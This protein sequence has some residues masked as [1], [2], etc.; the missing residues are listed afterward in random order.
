[1]GVGSVRARSRHPHDFMRIDVLPRWRHRGVGSGIYEALLDRAP[2]P[3]SVREML[4]DHP[5]VDF[6]T[7]RGFV[8]GEVATEGRI[9]PADPEAAIW[10]N[11]RLEAD[12]RGFV[13][14]PTRDAGMTDFEIAR[15]VDEMYVWCH[16]HSPP[17][18][19]S[20]DAATR[21]YLSTWRRQSGAVATIDGETVGVGL[22]TRSP[23]SDDP[24]V[25]H[26]VWCGVRQPIQPLAQEI[27]EALLAQC[28]DVARRMRWVV[29]V[30]VNHPHEDLASAVER[31]P[32]A[33]L[34]RDLTLLVSSYGG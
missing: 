16:P 23:F 8:T 15:A 21:V 10:L 33:R 32:G 13:I 4:S 9:D 19:L 27:T 17:A 26:L 1:M 18:P 11:G 31:V 34:F 5:T 30:E 28:L 22:L 29:D 20:D 14:T 6:Y 24:G 3:F 12:T 2:G 7:N 25:A